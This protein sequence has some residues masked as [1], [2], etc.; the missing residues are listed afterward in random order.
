MIDAYHSYVPQQK[1][2]QILLPPANE[3][4]VIPSTKGLGMPD[5]RSLLGVLGGCALFRIP[6]VEMEV[7][8]LGPRSLL[9]CMPGLRSLL[10]GSVCLVH[11]K[12]RYTPWEGTIPGRYI[13][14]PW[15]VHLPIL[16]SSNGHLLECYLVELKFYLPFLT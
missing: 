14:P 15:K 4:S 8:M 11:P 2:F 13:P 16:T 5:P 12:G 1:V 6:S 10:R 3:V 9:E 7:G